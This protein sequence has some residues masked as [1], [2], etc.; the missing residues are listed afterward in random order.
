MRLVAIPV[1]AQ[2]R[3]D[4]LVPVRGQPARHAQIDPVRTPLQV[5]VNEDKR[6]AFPGLP[7]RQPRP[8]LAKKVHA[9][10]IPDDTAARSGAQIRSDRPR[11]H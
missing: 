1:P 3:H 2:V 6:P 10:I 7:V 8:V 11:R 9:S 5:P 4:H